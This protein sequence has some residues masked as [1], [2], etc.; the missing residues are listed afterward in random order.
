MIFRLACLQI[1]SHRLRAIF[2]A[3]AAVLTSILYMT[4]ISISYCIL[5]STQ[6]SR[7]LAGG[8]DFHASVSDTGYSVLAET[9]R[10]EI[11]NA[12][13]VAEAFLL[14]MHRAVS[15]DSADTG[16]AH[17]EMEIAFTDSEK[18]LSHLFMTPTQ[19]QF[20]GSRDEIML[21]ERAFS[22]VLVGDHIRFTYDGS[23][24]ET[25]EK[26]YTVSGFYD[27][28][29]DRPVS[30]VTLYDENSVQEFGIATQVMIRFHS[31]FGIDRR[32]EAVKE[33]LGKWELSGSYRDSQI[34]YA[35]A[36]ADL[37][38][39]FRPGNVLLILCVVAV[40]FFAAFLLIYNIFSIS[41]AQD[42]RKFGLLRVIGTTHRQMR[43]LT[44]VQIIL[45]GCGALPTGLLLGYFIGFRVLSPIFMSLSGKMLPYRFSPWIALISAGLTSFT[46][47]FSA[48]RPLKRIKKMT[49]V[50]SVS[51]GP[52]EDCNKKD[53]RREIPASARSLALAGI[54]RSRGRMLITSLSAMV[55][56]LLFVIV[57]G[58]VDGFIRSAL[59]RLGRFD[60]DLT[61]AYQMEDSGAISVAP[62]SLESPSFRAA[63]EPDVIERFAS[64]D[65]VKEI[66]LLRFERIRAK[67]MPLLEEKIRAYLARQNS[68]FAR[69]EYKDILDSGLINAVVLGIPDE[70]CQ[71]LVVSGEAGK[72]VSYDG[73]ELYDGSH[74]LCVSTADSGQS[75]CSMCFYTGDVLSSEA[76]ERNYEVIGT[77]LPYGIHTALS[78]LCSCEYMGSNEAL[79][80][81]PMSVF[82]KEFHDAPVFTLLAN[83]EES[84][85][86][87][88]REEAEEYTDKRGMDLNGMSYRYRAAG[89]LNRLADLRVRLAALRLTGYSLCGIIFL[90]GLLNMI[91][92]A[93]T[94]M[95]LRRREFAMLETVGMTRAQL[96]RMLLYENSTGGVFGLVSFAVGSVLS[97]TLL[98]QAFGVDIALI[99][100]PAMGILLFLLAAGGVTAEVSYRMLTRTSLTERV[101]L[102]E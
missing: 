58:L 92:S 37:G 90:I 8:S 91:N 23:D 34:N 68:E 60:I 22:A 62:P 101:R 45:I 73:E 49:P 32:L 50:Q 98:T 39:F 21:Y 40:V 25:K 17:Q 33:R 75:F 95:V 70:L 12:P 10:R 83:A 96:R 82:E 87:S 76:L 88:L 53:R 67:M 52:E 100:V 85:G 30:A 27:C 5:D 9:L 19:G 89:K 81:L 93:L 26:V 16:S 4:V 59:D 20:P 72:T 79:F 69:E 38:E 77:E 78:E 47:F 102:G 14:G 11:Q 36:A 28:D 43:R 15:A 1:R 86:E 55:S 80:L 94:S 66:Y 65:A 7:M 2:V 63:I 31:G 44:C 42:M 18:S 51:P 3:V 46:L 97:S 64:S 48:L 6:L 61:L 13:E 71:Y 84:M 35:Y 99:S 56:V 29:A 24:G 41:L 74:V 57:G 54:R